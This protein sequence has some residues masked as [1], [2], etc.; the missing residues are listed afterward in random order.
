MDTLPILKQNAYLT[1]SVKENHIFANLA[2]T[3]FLA[4]KTYML[5]DVTDLSPLKFRMDDI[6]FNK[7]FWFEYFS[8]LEK[9]LDWD[10]VDKQWEGIFKVIKFQEEGVGVGGIKIFVDDNQPFFNKIYLSLKEFSRD[11]VLRVVDDKYMEYLIEG[12]RDRLGYEDILWI[13]MDLSHFTVY[14]SRYKGS[15]S[16][17]F[18]RKNKEDLEFTVSKISWSSEIGLIDSIK[19]SKLQAFLSVQSN[20]EEILNRWANFVANTPENI[21]DSFIEDILRSFTTIQNLSIKESNRGK[22]DDFGREGSAVIL[23]G[24]LTTLLDRRDL[25]LSI[26]D[27]FELEGV[28]DLYIDDENRLINFGKNLIEASQSDEIMVIKR[29]V[30]PHAVKV[31]VPE[32]PMKAKAKVVFSGKL[33]SQNFEQRDIYAF[34]PTLEVFNIPNTTEKVVLEGLLRNG[35]VLTHYSSNEISFVSGYGG[36]LYNS[37][38]I[39][40]RIRP[41]IYGPK[42]EDNRIKLQNWK[43]GNK[44]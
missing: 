23:T 29:D 3:D 21:S 43:D 8:S 41:V 31:I 36:V 24:K 13:D 15:G 27:G 20:N 11:I 37:L 17:I 25:Y 10:I 26:I 16:S 18:K 40:C 44:E 32:V 34:N 1:I 7:Y 28:F 22:L 12:L 6:V 30:V 9:A 5:S 39:D 42:A 38:I 2:Y 33:M 4:Q 19:N 14:R 35:S